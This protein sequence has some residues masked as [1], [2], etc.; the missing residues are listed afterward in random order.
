MNHA[1]SLGY[2]RYQ[3]WNSTPEQDAAARD[4]FG[5]FAQGGYNVTTHN[6]LGA[7]QAALDGA[8]ISYEGALSF[9]PNQFFNLNQRGDAFPFNGAN[10]SGVIE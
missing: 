4:A 8:G 2:D 7:V 3:G 6:C 5:N 10:F 9:V 1:S